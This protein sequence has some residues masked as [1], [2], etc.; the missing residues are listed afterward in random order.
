LSKNFKPL[1]TSVSDWH[2][3]ACLNFLSYMSYGYIEGYLQA[4]DTLVEDV[5]NDG[6][7][8]D[9]LVY[10]IVFYIGTT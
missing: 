4:A 1:F 5:K 2:N 10:P 9:F 8:K 7:D 6:S 3:N